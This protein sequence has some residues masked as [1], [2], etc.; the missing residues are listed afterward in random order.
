MNNMKLDFLR[1]LCSQLTIIEVDILWLH[2]IE[3]TNQLT[4]N[5]KYNMRDFSEKFDEVASEKFSCKLYFRPRVFAI[6]FFGSVYSSHP[7][8]LDALTVCLSVKAEHLVPPYHS[9][10]I[11]TISKRVKCLKITFIRIT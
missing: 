10:L 8:W 3:L 7:R 2:R 1:F 9:I 11:Y 4:T 5:H 6:F